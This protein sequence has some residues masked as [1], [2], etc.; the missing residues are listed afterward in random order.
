MLWREGGNGGGGLGGGCGGVRG[1]ARLALARKRG[2]ENLE[3]S[4]VDESFLKKKAKAAGLYLAHEKGN[5]KVE[6]LG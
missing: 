2:E 4:R 6:K 1:G 3:M 5:E